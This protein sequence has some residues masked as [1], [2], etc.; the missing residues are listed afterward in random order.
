MTLGRLLSELRVFHEKP[1][2]LIQF[3][4][5][6]ENQWT[7]LIPG[8]IVVDSTVKSITSS[9]AMG[10]SPKDVLTKMLSMLRGRVLQIQNNDKAKPFP[11]PKDITLG[12]VQI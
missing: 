10:S 6:G 1:D 5:D 11:V 7:A 9:M 8:Y 3:T 4:W 12:D 2:L